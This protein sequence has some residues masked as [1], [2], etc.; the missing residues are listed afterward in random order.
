MIHFCI[1]CKKE[2]ELD[3]EGYC[4]YCG[5]PTIEI[6]KGY[7]QIL[8]DQIDEIEISARYTYGSAVVNIG[9]ERLR[10]IKKGYTKDHDMIHRDGDLEKAVCA[11][12]SN[13]YTGS[14]IAEY[15]LDKHK[16]RKI[17]LIIAGALIVAALDRLDLKEAY[18]IQETL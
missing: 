11:I 18:E 17:K 4:K 13:D 16:E 12:L 3:S 5:L 2:A 7:V 6:G 1:G 8:L 15:V 14:V 10:Q 9:E